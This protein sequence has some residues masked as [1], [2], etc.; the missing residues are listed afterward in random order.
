VQLDSSF[1]MCL[2]NN[3]MFMQRSS[4]CLLICNCNYNCTKRPYFMAQSCKTRGTSISTLKVLK[5]VY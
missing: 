5:P 3:W 1:A 4:S 2:L